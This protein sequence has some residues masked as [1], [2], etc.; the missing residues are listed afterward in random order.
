MN[1]G[2]QINF[3]DFLGNV[4][5]LGGRPK[6][7]KTKLALQVIELFPG[8]VFYMTKESET[9]IKNRISKLSPERQKMVHIVKG[10]KPPI[11]GKADGLIVVDTINEHF[12]GSDDVLRDIKNLEIQAKPRGFKILFLSHI[13]RHTKEDDLEVELELSGTPSILAKMDSIWILEPAELDLFQL[14]VKR[15]NDD[16]MGMIFKLPEL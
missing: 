5:F 13:K 8:E 15:K 3:V 16:D 1:T 10:E 7:G 9:R 12:K 6:V 11:Q 14:T 4:T 2:Q